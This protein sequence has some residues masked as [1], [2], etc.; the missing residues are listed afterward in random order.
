MADEQ[1]VIKVDQSEQTSQCITKE[2]LKRKGDGSS[3]GTDEPIGKISKDFEK[4]TVKEEISK[5]SKEL[6]GD[7]E[8]SKDSENLIGGAKAFKDQLQRSLDSKS[9]F[10]MNAKEE[11]IE[12]DIVVKKIKELQKENVELKKSKANLEKEIEEDKR[13]LRFF[14]RIEG[15]DEAEELKK[16]IDEVVEEFMN[17]K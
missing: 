11:I 8:A 16:R 4:S 1:N 2:S 6:S 17:R 9:S 13:K 14:H 12:N 15:T 3:I 7:A 10:L 5:D